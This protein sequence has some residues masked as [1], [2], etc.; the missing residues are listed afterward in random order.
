MALPPSWEGDCNFGRNQT[1]K[2]MRSG[3]PGKSLPVPAKAG[4]SYKAEQLW[5]A[6]RGEMQFSPMR[7]RVSKLGILYKIVLKRKYRTEASWEGKPKLFKRKDFNQDVQ[8]TFNKSIYS[9]KS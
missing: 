2:A 3:A 6:Q 1:T 9:S 5:R 7:N 4:S 8:L